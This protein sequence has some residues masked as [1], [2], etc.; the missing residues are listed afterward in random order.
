MRARR[1][2]RGS[3]L[4]TTGT[5]SRRAPKPRPLTQAQPHDPMI[6]S[7]GATVRDRRNAVRDASERCPPSIGTLSAFGRNPCPPSSESASQSA[8]RTMPMGVPLA[9]ALSGAS[10]RLRG[11]YGA[12]GRQGYEDRPSR[13]QAM[14]GGPSKRFERFAR[15]LGLNPAATVWPGATAPAGPSATSRSEP[16]GPRLSGPAPRMVAG[17]AMTWREDPCVRGAEVGLK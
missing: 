1:G 5:A 10:G 7:T 15:R 13:R 9:R 6:V 17:E 8:A 12:P 11:S 4:W 16:A 2:A 3:P 14:G